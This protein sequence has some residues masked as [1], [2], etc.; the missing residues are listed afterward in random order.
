M[1]VPYV[2]AP[3]PDEIIGSWL[4]RTA[5]YNDTGAWKSLLEHTGYGLR[6]HRLIVDL[7]DNSQPLSHLLTA[8]GTTYEHALTELTTLPYWLAFDATSNQKSRVPGTRS[9]PR[10]FASCG[11]EKR[12]LTPLGLS[13]G[14]GRGREIRF[15]PE[16]VSQDHEVHGE[17]YWHRAHQLP[18]VFFCPEHC[19][20]LLTRCHACNWSGLTLARS[21]VNCV[22]IRCR[23][24]N[25]LRRDRSRSRPSVSERQLIALSVSALNSGLPRWSN[26]QVRTFLKEALGESDYGKTLDTAFPSG[27]A[28]RDERVAESDHEARLAFRPYFCEARAPEC[29]ALL[30]AM[31]IDFGCAAA[32]FERQPTIR[33]ASRKPSPIHQPMSIRAARAELLA[34]AERSLGKPASV[35]SRTIY[36]YLFFNDS[37]W[38]LAKFPRI[39]QIPS[40]EEDRTDILGR[41]RD[42]NLSPTRR[43][44]KLINTTAY[45]RAAFRDRAWLDRQLLDL[46]TEKDQ[47]NGKERHRTIS[48]RV[49]LLR[50]ALAAY[51]ENVDRP[52]RVSYVK[53]AAASGLTTSQ[54]R[55]AVRS[56][57]QLR[58]E[59]RQ[60]N[61]T[62]IERQIQFAVRQ[63]LIE[64]YQLSLKNVLT[65]AGLQS[66]SDIR[67]IVRR[68]IDSNR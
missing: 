43:R 53:L 22:P 16:C 29:C 14:A 60:F 19:R 59:I 65:R 36:W 25:D 10:I 13:R 27:R 56:S 21:L 39:N 40:L 46:R 6:M 34:R 17:P 47:R 15:C 67:V 48:E 11:R 64:G 24:G 7:I 58:V 5:A 30:A 62:K 44:D 68:Q 2:P 26:R 54:V 8:L 1:Y 32:G 3:H 66:T 52:S 42:A 57:D 38:L 18:N 9:V 23:C 50:K 55:N 4:A 41:I 51:L 12:L 33:K 45:N 28:D 49:E 35:L 20:P 61:E 37:A 31:S 63:L